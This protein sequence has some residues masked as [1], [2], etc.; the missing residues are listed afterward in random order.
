MVLR[1]GDGRESPLKYTI[2]DAATI[3]MAAG[4]GRESPLKYTVSRNLPSLKMLGMAGN[5]RSS[6]LRQS[7]A[8]GGR[9]LG[10]AGNHRSSTLIYKVNPL[11][12]M[13]GMAGN[14]RSSTLAVAASQ[15][16]QRW[17]WP[18][19]TAQVH[20]WIRTSSCAWL[21]MAG[22][23]RS[24]TLNHYGLVQ[25]FLLGMAGNHRSSTLS[26]ASTQSRWPLG[27]AG[28]HRSST[29]EPRQPAHFKQ[30][31]GVRTFRKEVS[32]PESLPVASAFCHRKP[33]SS[34]IAGPSQ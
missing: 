5:H 22:N 11:N 16:V 25:P 33:P 19:I 2:G 7:A 24:S 26:K 29:L 12:G 21:G 18:G 6:T 1:A 4:D 14:H 10:M 9:P 20:F 32:A 15:A 27:M 13:L 30:V 34:Q 17:G 31:G 23:H 3:L 28:N 8:L